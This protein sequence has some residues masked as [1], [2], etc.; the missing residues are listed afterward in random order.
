VTRCVAI[1]LAICL[2]GPAAWGHT[3]PQV[4]TV[5]VQ[6]ERCELVLLVGYRPQ[7]GEPTQA[8]LARVASQPKPRGLEALR[9]VLTAYAMAP[10]TVAVDGK[11]LVP[12]SVRA[13]IGVEPGGGRPMV[14]VLVSYPLRG[15]GQLSVA[16]REPRTTQISWQDRGSGR[17][18]PRDAPAQDRWY[19]GVASFLL[20]LAAPTGETACGPSTRRSD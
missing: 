9:G 6:V 18:D 16:T 7:S 10:L 19:P 15:G 5:V 12:S 14:V 8:I 1:A 13:K 3:F 4:R 20:S 17:I 2:A 11:P